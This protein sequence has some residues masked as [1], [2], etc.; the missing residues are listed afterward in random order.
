MPQGFPGSDDPRVAAAHRYEVYGLVLASDR[1]LASLAPAARPVE[2]ALT[3][4][5]VEPAVLHAIIRPEQATLPEGHWIAHAFLA[6]GRFYLHA[7]GV[8]DAILSADGRVAHCASADPVDARTVEAN[9]LNIVL[10]SALTLQGEEPLHATAVDLGGHA[11]AFLGPSGAGKTTLAASLIRD[12]ATLLTDDVLRIVFAD[13]GRAIAQPG[14]QRLKVL[15]DTAQRYTADTLSDGTFNPLSGKMM[16]KPSRARPAGATSGIPLRA[17]YYLGDLPGHAAP[18]AAAAVALS[19]LEVMR[20]LLSSAMDDRNTSAAR[21]ARQLA[22]MGRLA[23]AVS[24]HA[25]RYPRRFEAMEDV[26]AE[27]R[28]TALA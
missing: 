15:E 26:A 28:R 8:V 2:P 1:P 23:A 20:V 6:D 18:H 10:G 3:V 25:L 7:P 27:I 9:L 16:V 13:D 14:P 21:L 17:L 12:G 11:V 22:F 19:G 4:R 24:I 5:F